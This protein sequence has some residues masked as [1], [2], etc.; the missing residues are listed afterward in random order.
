V[1]FSPPIHIFLREFL[2]TFDNQI[3]GVGKVTPEDFIK[4]Y[5]KVSASI[6]QDDYFELMIR[7]AWHIEGSSNRRVLVNHI[8]GRQTVEEIKVN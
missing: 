4:Y 7:N 5:T 1:F 3:D 6:E 8:D 2:D